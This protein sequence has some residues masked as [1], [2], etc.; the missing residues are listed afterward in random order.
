LLAELVA[1]VE[2]LGGQAEDARRLG[3]DLAAGGEA[4]TSTDPSPEGARRASVLYGLSWA[5][6]A[7]SVELWGEYTAAL[8]RYAEA[9]GPLAPV[10]AAL[11]DEVIDLYGQWEDAAR[12]CQ[13]ICEAIAPLY[14]AQADEQTRIDALWA[15][16]DELEKCIEALY[17][18]IAPRETALRGTLQ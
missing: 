2:R 18:Q 17:E 5:A 11:Y 10:V 3:E 14:L 6:D 16:Q 13:A 12:R 9:L 7:R 4:L 8:R 1:E 15:E